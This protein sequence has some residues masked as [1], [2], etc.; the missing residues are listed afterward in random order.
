M[1]RDRWNRASL[2][3]GRS[4]FAG[5]DEEANYEWNDSIYEE[6]DAYYMDDD[7]TY[8]DNWWE[9]FDADAVYY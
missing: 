9:S 1:P 3:K 6:D 4:Y 5:D 8:D 2:G 7:G